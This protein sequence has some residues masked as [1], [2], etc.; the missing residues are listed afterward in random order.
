MTR[1]T[2]P[3]TFS[4]NQTCV[5]VLGNGNFKG[6]N[7]HLR[8]RYYGIHGAI[9]KGELVVEHMAGADMVADGLT[10]PLTGIN[11]EKFMQMIGLN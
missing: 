1:I 11:H 3:L 8:L 6:D 10:K 2:M 5:T 9:A 7:H 4:D